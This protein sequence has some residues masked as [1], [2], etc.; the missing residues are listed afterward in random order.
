MP[1]RPILDASAMTREIPNL[2]RSLSPRQ[3]TTRALV[4]GLDDRHARAG[5]MAAKEWC[6]LRRRLSELLDA[7]ARGQSHASAADVCG[8]LYSAGLEKP[9]ER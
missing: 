5:G 7:N 8:V 4:L 2:Q 3:R 1:D 9:T 6:E